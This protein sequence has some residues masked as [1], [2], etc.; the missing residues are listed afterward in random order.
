MSTQESLTGSGAPKRQIELGTKAE[1]L[2]RLRPILKSAIVLPQI[3]FTVHQW[4]QYAANIVSNIQRHFRSGL[5]IVRSSTLFEDTADSSN[6]GVF[7]SLLNVDGHNASAIFD[8]INRVIKSYGDKDGN[9]QVLVQPQLTDVA[10]CGV[11]FT[12]DIQNGAPYYVINYDDSGATDKI[13]SGVSE[14]QQTHYVY[15][16]S[17]TPPND[18]CLAALIECAKEL[19]S[20]GKP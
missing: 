1:T 19:E 4:E 13:T 18:P 7:P 5:L 16:H 12:C 3:H 20:L 17:C 2:D 10:I 14:E 6:A 15:R 9:H 8:A 11:M